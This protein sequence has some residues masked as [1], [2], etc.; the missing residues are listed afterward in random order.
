V[1]I[2]AAYAVDF[3]VASLRGRSVSSKRILTSGLHCQFGNAG[4]RESV[5]D[6]THRLTV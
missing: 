4:I 1:S 6:F 3:V 5:I 2:A